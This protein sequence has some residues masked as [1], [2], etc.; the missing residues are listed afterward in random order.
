MR[1]TLALPLFILAAAQTLD[2][3]AATDPDPA[4]ARN[5]AGWADREAQARITDGDYDGALQA[6]RQANADRRVAA[7]EER[8]EQS[9]KP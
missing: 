1:I 4:A 5:Q 3:P 6:Q 7:Q 2:G 9:S 8:R